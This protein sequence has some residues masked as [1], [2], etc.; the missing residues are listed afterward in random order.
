MNKN[1]LIV[2]DEPTILKSFAFFLKKEGFTTFTAESCQKAE[3]LLLNNDFCVVVTDISLGDADG[4]ELLKKVVEIDPD[5]PVIL[6]TGQP[7]VKSA[8]EGVRLGAFDYLTKPVEKEQLIRVVDKALIHYNL[9]KNAKDLSKKLIQRERMVTALLNAIQESVILVDKNGIVLFANQV[10]AERLGV[11]TLELVGKLSFDFLPGEVAKRRKDWLNLV[12]KNKKHFTA[13]DKRGDHYFS[14]SAYPVLDEAGEVQSVALYAVDITK[15]KES[16][17]SLKWDVTMNSLLADISDKI[18]NRILSMEDIAF[19]ILKYSRDITDGKLGFIFVKA[20]PEF[21]Y[22]KDLFLHFG[23]EQCEIGPKPASHPIIPQPQNG[24][25]G[26]KPFP[27]LENN[28]ALRHEK[29]E[30]YMSAPIAIQDIVIGQL[31][32]ANK[33]SPFTPKEKEGIFKLAKI[34]SLVLK[35][36][37]SEEALKRSESKY[38]ALVEDANDGIL[39]IDITGNVLEVNQWFAKCTGF[40][41]DELKGRHISELLKQESRPTIFAAQKTIL[42]GKPVRMEIEVMCK[43]GED[44]FAEA[45]AKRVG[46]NRVQVMIRDITER[47]NLEKLKE[48][49]ERMARHDL[50]TPLNAIINLPELIR[51]DPLTDT[52]KEYLSLIQRSG[53]RMLKL[54][55]LSMDLY[56]ME[57]G[58]YEFTPER[59]DLV[60]I[61]K[62]VISEAELNNQSQNTRIEAYCEGRPLEEC[63]RFMA[64]G[65]ELLTYSMLANI[66][67]NAEEA[68]PDG[69]VITVNLSN[70]KNKAVIETTNQGLVPEDIKEIFFEK[71]V[72]KGKKQGTGLGTYSAKLMAQ[73][74]NGEIKM[75]SRPE[76]GTTISVFLPIGDKK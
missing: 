33:P 21:K 72:T 23:S 63:S 43:N 15:R 56:K 66:I 49:V 59:I 69:E 38:R 68:S 29:I 12:I 14:L 70:K 75:E 53:Y 11:T 44:F 48:E 24:K 62:K 6:I 27:M 31:A 7:S 34:F 16:E 22:L 73:V 19:S 17:A 61:V 28:P 71:Y 67:T 36:E 30:N 10:C 47:K 45:I 39:L 4:T 60:D 3:E 26:V 35:N 55:N 58:S 2:D 1:I 41:L 37:M 46:I 51:D 32:I 25:D 9:L 52:Q 40:G 64:M 57:T 65:E 50:K 8:S 13:E 20:N 74:Q 42:R 5:I 76:K 18:L 54:V